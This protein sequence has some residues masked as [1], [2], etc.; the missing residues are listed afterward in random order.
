MENKEHI[1]ISLGGSLIVPD[2][3]DIEFLKIFTE[4]IKKYIDQGFRFVII[5]GG[6]HTARNY[7]NASKT[8]TNP[9]VTD[10][11]WIGIATT[12]VNAELLRV[13]FGDIAHESIIMDPDHIPD[14][15][16][17]LLIGA[18]WKPGNSSDLA[19]VH[20]AKS[21]GAKKVINLSNIDYVYDKDPNKFSDASIVKESNWTDFRALLPDEWGPGL[22][23]PFDPVAAKEA[24][25]LGLEVVIMN[26]KNIENFNKYLNGEEFVGTVI[27]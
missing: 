1:I 18:G 7:I 5:T 26:G 17:S 23:A 10:L 20:S 12:R 8:I 24:E 27:H 9:S 11:D 6:G 19:A 13:A 22:N 4:N 2:E 25:S 14:T 3:V 21:V 16:K 15:T